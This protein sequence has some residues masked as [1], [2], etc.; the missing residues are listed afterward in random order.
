[1]RTQ[2]RTQKQSEVAS[3]LAWV[4]ALLA[5]LAGPVGAQQSPSDAD[6]AANI[7]I[8]HS[9]TYAYTTEQ[10]GAVRI[11]R[12]DATIH[13]L[14]ATASTTLEISLQNTTSSRQEAKLIIPIAEEAVVSGFA[15]SGTSGQFTAEVLPKAEAERIYNQLVSKIRDPALAEFIGYNLIGTSV[16]PIEPTGLQKVLLTYEHVLR[17]DGNRVDYC[18]PRTESLQYEVPW[19]ITASIESSRPISSVYSPS[20]M[21][22][23]HRTSPTQVTAITDPDA[24]FTPGP[25]L[26]SY[27]PEGEGISTSLLA[28]PDEDEDDAGYFLLLA[29]TP[30]KR[31]ED[32]NAIKRELTLVLDRSGSMWG[33]KIKQAQEAAN[34]VIS[35][36]DEGEAFNLII[37]NESIQRFSNE[38][39]IKSAATEAQAH[40]YIQATSAQGNTNL[41]GALQTALTQPPTPAMLPL[42]LFLT[43]GLPT[44]GITS[45]TA[46]RDLVVTSNPFERRV[47]TFGVGVDL[48]AP[49]LDGLAQLSRARSFFVLPGENVE[50]AVTNVFKSLTGPIFADATLR[51]LSV[52]GSEAI[53]RTQDVLPAVLPDLFDGDRLVL[54]GRYIGTAPLTFEFKGNFL[55]RPRTFAHTFA[56][57]HPDKDNGFIPRLWASRKIAELIESIRQ[58][59]ADPT[60]TANNAKIKELAETIVKLSTEFGII[61]EYTAFLARE[62]TDLSNAAQLLG[63]ATNAL[64]NTGVATRDGTAAV[65][66]SMNMAMQRAQDVL[67]RDSSYL[68]SGLERER[69][70]NAQ[71][72]NDLTFY[73]KDGR[74]IDSRLAEIQAI[75]TPHRTVVFGSE[76]FFDIAAR[77]ASQNRQ[78]ALAFAQ[79][80]LLLLDGEILLIDIP[81]EIEEP[82]QPVDPRTTDQ[83]DG[84]VAPSA[85]RGR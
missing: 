47:F 24:E 66:Q 52:D 19:K 77:L 54:L 40:S 55:G 32:V 62:G 3:V 80:I 25:F 41:Y 59:G 74:W 85:R 63:Q 46:I 67:N 42:V 12:V 17:T 71:Q 50:V 15:Y 43:D 1:M 84:T 38:P 28:Y 4:V 58:M 73:F 57:D 20:H 49:L 13:I 65:S 10:Q 82:Y 44:A 18:L 14:E 16:F 11:T 83:G 81:A 64:Y 76:E 22:Y 37:Y 26:L 35:G 69:I 23:T 51:V 34:Q 79:D 29:G 78:G 45:E 60:V 56:F 48:N 30:A 61:T 9:R 68:N 53:G 31:P 8:P 2:R 72:A 75:V 6:L 21:I 5:P 36:L 7:V 39:V 33:E 70:V 27:L